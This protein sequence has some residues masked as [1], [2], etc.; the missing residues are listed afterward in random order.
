MYNPLINNKVV[1]PLYS[2]VNVREKPSIESPN[3][4]TVK[5]NVAVGRTTGT[6]F[7]M[8]DSS[9]Y[10][11][12]FSAKVNNHEYGYVKANSVKLVEG[13]NDIS[14]KQAETLVNSLIEND[15]KIYSSLLKSAN[16][17]NS[18]K[19]K[20]INTTAYDTKFK[21]LLDRHTERQDKI[22]TSKLLSWKAGLDNTMKSLTDGFKTYLSWKFGI[23][24]GVIP[25]AA[26]VVGAVIGGGLATA[27]YFAFRPD[28]DE[29]KTDLIISSELEEALSKVTPETAIKIKAGL[30]KQVDDAYNSGKTAGSF[31]GMFSIIKPVAIGLL[32]F[33]A[34]QK[35]LQSQNKK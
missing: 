14:Q 28:Y 32:G 11:V 25:V 26:V 6:E 5:M 34:I 13:K 7:K 22:K 24:I 30:E 31:S 18:L 21:T 35:F 15:K 23:N 20:G 19:S 4:Q 27:A 16:I 29:S 8:K 3:I 2:V 12:L 9:W 1:Y 17:L 10:Q 33:F